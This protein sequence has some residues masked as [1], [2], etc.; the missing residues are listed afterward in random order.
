MPESP[1]L[2]TTRPSLAVLVHDG[3][4][5]DCLTDVRELCKS[6]AGFI[7]EPVAMAVARRTPLHE[8]LGCL[9]GDAD[10]WQVEFVAPL[11]L[12]AAA[13]SSADF[14]YKDD[15]PD[16]SAMWTGLA[17]LPSTRPPPRERTHRCVTAAPATKAS[18]TS[19]KR[20]R[21]LRNH[22]LSGTLRTR[23]DRR[24]M[25][26]RKLRAWRRN[27]LLENVEAKFD[28]E[29]LIV[30]AHESFTLKNEVKS[31]ITVLAKTHHYWQAHVA[32]QSAVA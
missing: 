23:L 6:F 10:E 22:G 12:A 26:S 15:A 20:E 21:H 32:A 30:P 3:F 28:E 24:D 16:W 18:T 1:A 4:P 19:P 8:T 13:M 27:N 9:P 25:G 29:R 2:Q 17:S 31:V 5:T 11:S 7:G 14:L